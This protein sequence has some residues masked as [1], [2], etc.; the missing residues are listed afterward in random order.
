MRISRMLFVP[1]ALLL[2]AGAG[3]QKA[4]MP[5]ASHSAPLVSRSAPVAPA[6]APVATL[7]RGAAAAW[8][9]T[10]S[11]W[12]GSPPVPVHD[13]RQR[14]F[15]GRPGAYVI[16]V[17]VVVPYAVPVD[18]YEVPVAPDTTYAPDPQAA[19]AMPVIE[20]HRAERQLTTIEVYRLQPRFQRP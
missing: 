7:P 11:K 15:V 8:T 6:H 2:A 1:G 12:G 13:R 17:V 20:T 19:V 9:G 10:P 16:P 18:P 4:S 14:G 5:A 3:A